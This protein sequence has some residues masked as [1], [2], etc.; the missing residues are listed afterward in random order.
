MGELS[1]LSNNIE[2]VLQH[3]EEIK[4]YAPYAFSRLTIKNPRRLG[5]QWYEQ[6]MFMG[7]YVEVWHQYL[8]KSPEP[9]I[10]PLY[11]GS[12]MFG[13]IY[14]FLGLSLADKTLVKNVPVGKLHTSCMRNP[15]WAFIQANPT[16]GLGVSLSQVV[17][18]IRAGKP[19]EERESYRLLNLR[20]EFYRSVSAISGIR[21]EGEHDL[22]YSL[23]QGV[24]YQ[25]MIQV[26]AVILLELSEREKQGLVFGGSA[27]ELN[28]M[29]TEARKDLAAIAMEAGFSHHRV[30]DARTNWARVRFTRQ[31][32]SLDEVLEGDSITSM[33]G[34]LYAMRK[35]IR[36]L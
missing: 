2:L 21:S 35:R 32:S 13:T 4:A 20:E 34:M 7:A 16:R 9:A 5:G 27:V 23:E 22:A 17:E 26:H 10:L 29:V 15:M 33:C 30:M 12:G 36:R 8:Q 11:I 3:R 14:K 19:L 24:N 6:N 31:I 25:L 18:E 1:L 28:D